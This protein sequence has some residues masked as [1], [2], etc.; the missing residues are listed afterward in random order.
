MA[1]DRGFRV[2]N[3][4]ESNKSFSEKLLKYRFG[5][6]LKVSVAAIVAV[7]VIV[8]LMIQYKNQIYTGVV[9]SVSS[10]KSNLE[11]NSYLSSDGSIVTYSKDGISTVDGN[12][13]VLWNMTYEMQSPIVHSV[14]GYVAVCDY[15]GHIIY[16]INSSGKVTEID[17]NLP[18]RDFAIS[19]DAL[20]AAILEDS[21][22]SWINL[23][24][25]NCEQ[26]VEIKATM[27]KT[28]YPLTLTLN[29]EV[30]GV[31]YLYVDGDT[32]KSSVTFYNFGG[33]GE[34]VSDHIVSSY[35][36]M[37]GVVP[38]I[39]FINDETVAA[40]GD[41]RLMFFTGA[42]KP[43]S[44]S[45]IM[46]NENIVGVYTGGEHV[47]LMFYD[48]TGD[49]KYRLDMYDATGKLDYTYSFDTD[50]KDVIISNK[51]V[52]IYNEINCIILNEDGREKFNGQFPERVIFLGATASN[53]RY[54]AVTK[55]SVVNFNFE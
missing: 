2:L 7:L 16:V 44:T 8:L 52:L 47:G 30:M 26:L 32:L 40:V 53:K 11:N 50:Y 21:N 1:Y 25:E 46:I 33:I 28:G 41:N 10:E 36:Y 45:D 23:Y 35:D 15:G 29:D 54:I 3:G 14:E 51:Q 48:T 34:N 17:T 5:V 6:A 9:A 39:S 18:I 42:K 43:V 13:E 37:N 19:K 55:D 4:G 22:T 27:S 12:G 20:V 24:N 49:Y 31:S 38:I